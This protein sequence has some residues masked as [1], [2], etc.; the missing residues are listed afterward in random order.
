MRDEQ[1]PQL[2][3]TDTEADF[4]LYKSQLEGLLA[5]ELIE[6]PLYEERMGRA[7]AQAMILAHEGSSAKEA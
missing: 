6:L 7:I 4:T 5:R 1:Q 3:I 2:F